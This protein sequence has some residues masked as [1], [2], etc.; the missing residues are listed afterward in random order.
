MVAAP[1][2][3]V[4]L[5]E[6]H[7][8]AGRRRSRRAP[9]LVE[10][11]QRQQPFRFGLGQQLDE[12]P[13]QADRFA[14]KIV[15]RQRGARRSRVPFVE[16]QI[17]HVEN[18]VQ[19]A[20]QVGA[21]RHLIRNAR[22]TDLRLGADDPLRDGRRNS[23]KRPRDF[24]GGEAAHLAERE[25]DLRIGR[26]GRMAA[27]EDEAQPI[28]LD[29]VVFEVF[30]LRSAARPRLELLGEPRERRLEP[31]TAADGVDRL[32]PAG[33]N[34]PRPRV[35]RHAVLRPAF[36][37]GRERVVKR[38]LGEVEIAEQANQG[39]EDAARVGTVDSI[40]RLAGSL[41]CVLAHEWQGC[42]YG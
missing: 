28:V 17:D 35:V 13:H 20:R 7:E 23:K 25:R 32:E 37:R 10:Q 6:Q 5:V 2:R 18:R 34:E 29:A 3:A 24:L 27:G 16:H 21:R 14:R 38:L 22:V 11:H 40:Y 4:L 8:L 33:R 1:E 9:R 36:H 15:A 42:R 39:G 26:K 19:A 31:G 41:G 12:Q 30:E